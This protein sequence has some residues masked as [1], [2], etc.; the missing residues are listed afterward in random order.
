[1]TKDEALRVALDALEKLFGIPDM[2]TGENGG[3]VAVWRLGG[4]YRTQQAITAIKQALAAPVQ[5]PVGWISNKDFEPIRIRI[6]Q[7][8]YELAD[9]ND[10]EGYN[11]IKVMCGDVQ[12]MLSPQRT[13]VG[14]TE[15]D[16]WNL[17]RFRKYNTVT[18]E[19]A[20]AIEAK[21]KQKNGYTEEKNT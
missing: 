2:L 9:N 5:E 17:L 1:M 11:A 6:M 12:K 15:E 14:L 21:L 16:V 10:P 19:I 7:E 13:W 4:S 3:D 18:I 20:R 8:A